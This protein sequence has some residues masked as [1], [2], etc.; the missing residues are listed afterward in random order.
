MMDRAVATAIVDI[1]TRYEML[2]YS[3]ARLSTVFS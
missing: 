2:V 3:Q 1:R